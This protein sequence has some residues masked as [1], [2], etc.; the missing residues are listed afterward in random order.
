[1][2]PDFHIAAQTRAEKSEV[3]RRIYRARK[4]IDQSFQRPLDLRQISRQ[5][6]FSRY[7]FLR[8]FRKTFNQTPHQYLT[9][10]RIQRAKQLLGESNLSVTEICFEVGFESV[11]SFC[12]LFHKHVGSPPNLY[13]TQMAKRKQTVAQMPELSAP[14][15]FLKMFGVKTTQ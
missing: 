10:R 13:R 5:A 14:A 11:G 6:Y 2:I 1:M 9:Q 7:H 15:C 3:Y 4:F 12:S 8:L